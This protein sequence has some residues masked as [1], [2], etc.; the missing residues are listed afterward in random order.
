MEEMIWA[1]VFVEDRGWV[2]LKSFQ[3]CLGILEA[4]HT[5][6]FRGFNGGFIIS[7]SL[8]KA[9]AI[10]D[11]PRQSPPLLPSWKVGI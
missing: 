4:L 1:K 8:I 6:S 7:S 10:G 3:A 5:W 9:L 11:S 2:W